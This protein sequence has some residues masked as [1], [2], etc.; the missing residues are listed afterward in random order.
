MSETN[1]TNVTTGGVS[2]VTLLGVIF[3]C[4]KVFGVEPVA[5]WSWLWVLCPFWIG[6]AIVAVVLIVFGAGA[7]LLLAGAALIDKYNT[8]KRIRKLKQRT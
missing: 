2:F 7:G 8:R 6:I 4:A 5:H 3:V 1:T